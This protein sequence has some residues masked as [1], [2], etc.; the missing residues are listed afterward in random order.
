M[1]WLYYGNRSDFM[2]MRI[3]NHIIRGFEESHKI[4]IKLFILIEDCYHLKTQS[5]ILGGN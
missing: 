4:T 1:Q 5:K 3:F 2:S